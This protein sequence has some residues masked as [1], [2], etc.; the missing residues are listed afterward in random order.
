MGCIWNR[1][2]GLNGRKV[3]YHPN[4]YTPFRCDITVFCNP[5]GVENE[6]KVKVSNTGKNSRWYSGSGIY[7]HVWLMKTEKIHLDTWHTA[8]TTENVSENEATICISAEV[9]NATNRQTKCELFFEIYDPSGK[10]INDAKPVFSFLK[11]NNSDVC[12]K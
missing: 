12:K 7:R 1:K 10:R 9:F 5:P 2:Y 11:S 3:F 8:V 4:G 6:L